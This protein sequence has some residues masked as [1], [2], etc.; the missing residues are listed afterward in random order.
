MVI[1]SRLNDEDRD[2][3]ILHTDGHTMIGSFFNS[4]EMTNQT[5]YFIVES[6]CEFSQ[7]YHLCNVGGGL[8]LSDESRLISGDYYVVTNGAGRRTKAFKERVHGRDQD[9][10]L[11]GWRS[12]GHQFHWSGFHA[13]HIFPLGYEG[14]WNEHGLGR[15]ITNIP[16][17]EGSINSIQNG[18]MLLSSVHT[19]FD[20]YEIAVNPL[21]NYK[22]ICFT[23]GAMYHGLG[24][25]YLDAN[26]R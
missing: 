10:V 25:R 12:G 17:N 15:Y 14:Y 8:V 1:Q 5:L 11:S 18:I 7:L 4:P 21:D 6:F 3:R 9:C 22:V 19:F 20:N 23:K 16:G 13:A 24:G 26:L 2:T